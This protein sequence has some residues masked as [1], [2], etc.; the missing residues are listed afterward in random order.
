MISQEE[1]FILNKAKSLLLK[2]EEKIKSSLKEEMP[3]DFIKDIDVV[4]SDEALVIADEKINCVVGIDLHETKKPDAYL[5][6]S[7]DSAVV[8]K[9]QNKLEIADKDELAKELI[10]KGHKD[11]IEA[12]LL[13]NGGLYEAYGIAKKESKEKIKAE[14]EQEIG[15]AIVEKSISLRA[16][17][18]KGEKLAELLQSENVSRKANKLYESAFVFSSEHFNSKEES[19]YEENL[20]MSEI[21]EA[22][23]DAPEKEYCEDMGL[24]SV[25]NTASVSVS[26]HILEKIKVEDIEHTKCLRYS[27][28]ND[29]LKEVLKNETLV[30]AKI[31]KGGQSS[32]FGVVKSAEELIGVY[33]KL[34]SVFNAMKHSKKEESSTKSIEDLVEAKSNLK[35][36]TLDEQTSKNEV[37]FKIDTLSII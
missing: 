14:V 20:L 2:K 34:E 36:D 31:I 30:N 24:Y 4:D 37:E 16:K 6:S 29:K 15:E 26:P 28:N 11:C 33:E 7:S 17:P 10:K 12:D 23:L 18:L 5:F 9:F 22:L 13:P 35:L 21:E 27:F 8:V 19:L 1:L 32:I 25:V 3:F